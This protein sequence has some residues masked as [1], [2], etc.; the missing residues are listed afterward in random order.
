MYY[1][2]CIAAVFL[3]P[4]MHVVQIVIVTQIVIKVLILYQHLA[5]IY[6]I[7]WYSLARPF[8]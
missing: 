8:K 2:I 4:D 5:A 7:Y 6:R 3:H 1:G